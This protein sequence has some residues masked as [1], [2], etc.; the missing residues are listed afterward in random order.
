MMG[1]SGGVWCSAFLHRDNA[2]EAYFGKGTKVTVLG[3]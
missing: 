2:A 1:E 3:K